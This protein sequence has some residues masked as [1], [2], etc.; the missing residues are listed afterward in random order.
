MYILLLDMVEDKC[1]NFLSVLCKSFRKHTTMVQAF[2]L[3]EHVNAFQERIVA[4][5]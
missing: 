5:Q 3:A 4:G 1:R 2:G